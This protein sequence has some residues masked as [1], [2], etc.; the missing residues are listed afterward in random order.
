MRAVGTRTWSPGRTTL[1]SSPR[2]SNHSVRFV[3]TLE[4]SLG[5]G[6]DCILPVGVDLLGTAISPSL[7]LPLLLPLTITRRP[8]SH[9]S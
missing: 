3:D 7:L 8:I 4:L 6:L 5:G 1:S 9:D 2:M